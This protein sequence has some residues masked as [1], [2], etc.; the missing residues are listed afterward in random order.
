MAVLLLIFFGALGTY[1]FHLGRVASGLLMLGMSV[2]GW[3]LA[4]VLID[5]PIRMSGMVRQH[6]ERLAASFATAG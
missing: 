5:W 1:R 3:V 4:F 6:N 2:V